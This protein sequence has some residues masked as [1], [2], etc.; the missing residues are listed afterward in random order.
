MSSTY[1][2]THSLTYSSSPERQDLLPRRQYGDDHAVVVRGTVF[3]D[4]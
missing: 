4:L 3:S 1:S 2:R